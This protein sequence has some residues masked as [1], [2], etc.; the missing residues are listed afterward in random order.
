MLPGALEGQVLD[1]GVVGVNLDP[2]NGMQGGLETLN[3][4]WAEIV[5][6]FTSQHHG[7]C[8]IRL[9]ILGDSIHSFRSKSSPVIRIKDDKRTR[10]EVINR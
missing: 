8:L 1:L 7:E 9:R 4:V 3:G 5:R 6:L 2:V 10:A